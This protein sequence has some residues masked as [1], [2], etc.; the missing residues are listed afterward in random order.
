MPQGEEGKRS[1]RLI[2]SLSPP[3]DDDDEI[4]SQRTENE[5]S[6]EAWNDENWLQ[7]AEAGLA[8][9]VLVPTCVQVLGESTRKP[10]SQYQPHIIL[11]FFTC[12]AP[13]CYETDLVAHGQLSTARTTTTTTTSHASSSVRSLLLRPPTSATSA[14]VTPF[15]LP[16]LRLPVTSTLSESSPRSEITVNVTRIVSGSA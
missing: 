7:A 1:S 8:I 11:R 5:R 15:H 2:Q 14:I 3:N 6:T 9:D 12:P 10:A 4:T 13:T 16:R